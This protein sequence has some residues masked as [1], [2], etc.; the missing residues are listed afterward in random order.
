[1]ALSEFL[2]A[3]KAAAAR[4]APQYGLTADELYRALVVNA[5][6]EGGLGETPG[7]GDGGKSHGRFQF[8][9]AGGH[10]STLLAQ[11]WT[12]ADFYNETK[13]V[14]HWAP[15]LAQSLAEAKGKYGDTPEA[16]RQAIFTVERPAAVYSAERFNGLWQQAGGAGAVQGGG[17][18]VTQAPGSG[19]RTPDQE[20]LKRLKLAAEKT[21]QEVLDGAL[22]P[23]EYIKVLAAYQAY[24]ATGSFTASE[25]DA[26]QKAFDSAIALGDLQGK[27]AQAAYSRWKDK[28]DAAQSLAQGQLEDAANRN[29]MNRQLAV[30]R[31]A[32]GPEAE[33]RS[34]FAP[35]L[36]EAFDRWKGLLK[37]GDEPSSNPPDYGGDVSP[38]GPAHAAPGSGVSGSSGT[39]PFDGWASTLPGPVTGPVGTWAGSGE[40]LA[41]LGIQPGATVPGTGDPA[42]YGGVERWKKP[43]SPYVWT[44]S[45]FEVPGIGQTVNTKPAADA[46]TS[47]FKKFKKLIGLAGGGRNVPEGLYQVGEAGPE[48]AV[49]PSGEVVPLGASGPEV[50]M[51]PEGSDVLPNGIPPMQA[52]AY[53]RIRQAVAEDRAQRDDPGR[54]M[55]EQQRRASDP[56]LREKVLAALQQAVTAADVMNPPVT[57][58]LRGEGWANDPWAAWRPLTGQPAVPEMAVAPAKGGSR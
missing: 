45:P 25:D 38:P 17:T 10:G 24:A 32:N 3:S 43:E 47:G 18:A 27:Q 34:Y 28:R 33:V 42:D 57:P 15:Y 29:A 14:D 52:V 37:V 51:L 9:T 35:S 56:Q 44:F 46:V 36:G 7:V 13:V 1:M 50:A 40:D 8:N 55:A 30:Q 16:V 58:V 54:R 41:A 11:G 22:D 53:A 12:V 21:W 19:S 49:L 5:G 6:L 26:A 4:L 31:F 20:I 48:H 23:S 39:G 2:G